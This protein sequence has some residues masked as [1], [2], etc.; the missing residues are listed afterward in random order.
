MDNTVIV[1]SFGA[2]FL[3][4]IIASLRGKA[5]SSS[6]AAVFAFIVVLLWTVLAQFL[7]DK[8]DWGADAATTAELVKR[9][10]V[11]LLAAMVTAYTAFKAI[12]QPVG[13]TGQLEASGPQL[14]S[15]QQ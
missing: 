8:F 11:S 14:G 4:L 13:A 3:P 2:V 6:F 7:T 9:F 10:L 5:A 12:W 1:T 15:P